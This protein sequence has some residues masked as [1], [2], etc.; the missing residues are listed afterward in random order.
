MYFKAKFNNKVIYGI[1]T[2]SSSKNLLPLQRFFANGGTL[3]GETM[4]DIVIVPAKETHNKKLMIVHDGF[5]LTFR[6]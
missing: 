2:S 6:Y 3:G 5:D 4:T 1:F